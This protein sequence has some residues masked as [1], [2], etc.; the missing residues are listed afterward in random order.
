MFF[1][2]GKSG[3]LDEGNVGVLLLLFLQEEGGC[4]LVIFLPVRRLPLSAVLLVL[5]KI[6]F[7]DEVEFS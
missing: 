4:T 3:L 2:L 7:V 5:M 6:H 1:A